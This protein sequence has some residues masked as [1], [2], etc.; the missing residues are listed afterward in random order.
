MF[1][2][3]QAFNLQIEEEISINAIVTGNYKGENVFIPGNFTFTSLF[4]V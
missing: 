2:A 1:I 4:E 3:G